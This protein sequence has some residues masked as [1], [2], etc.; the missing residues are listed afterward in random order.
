MLVIGTTEAAYMLGIN[1]QRVRQ[2]LAERRVKGAYKDGY[3]W[4]IPLYKGMVD[5][6]PG[7]RGPKGTWRRRLQARPTYIHVNKHIIDSNRNRTENQPV[8]KV[9]RA[10]HSKYGHEVEITGPCRVVYRPH[11]PLCSGAVLWIE[12]EPST[13]VITKLYA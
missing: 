10:K 9:D 4:K 1:S 7:T 2:L 12:V 3:E 13:R 6:I 8:I 11:Q 5:I